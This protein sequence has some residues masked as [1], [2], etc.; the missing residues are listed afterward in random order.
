LPVGYGKDRVRDV[1]HKSGISDYIATKVDKITPFYVMELLEEAKKLEAAGEDIVHM[2]IGEPNFSTPE[3]IK[4]AALRAIRDNHTFYTESLGLPQLR[5]KIAE[6]Y[7]RDQKVSLSPGRIVITSGSSGAFSLLA[8][9]LLGRNRSLVMSDPGYPCYKNFGLIAGANLVP[10]PIDERSGFQILPSMIEDL[11]KRPHVVMVA[12]P[13]NPTGTIYESESL[14]ALR[15]SVTS[16]RGILLVDE[17]YGGLVY[18]GQFSSGVS[19]ADD[20]IV[21]DGFSK[22]FAMTG[23]RLGWMV[24]PEGLVRPV[25]KVSQNVYISAPTVSQYAAMAAF[26]AMEDVEQMKS[27]YRERRAYLLSQ[28]EQLGFQLPALPQGAFYIYAGIQRWNM[29]SMVF[30]KRAL[31]EAGVALTPGYDFGTYRAGEFVRFSYATEQPRLAEG[32]RRL[33]EW[34]RTL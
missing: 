4:E 3:P 2:E 23:W 13:S 34:F 25:Q 32:C 27:R 29:D 19:I 26:D 15:D 11:K 7:Y 10:I 31:S 24:V 14:R 16:R 21:V 9:V 1:G 33:K 12:N 20:V 30:V 28:L 18:D 22:V 8:A 5:E 6:H 17:I